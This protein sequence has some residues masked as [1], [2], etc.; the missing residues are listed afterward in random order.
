MLEDLK[1]HH[2]AVATKNITKSINVYQNLGYKLVSDVSSDP[3]QK[4]KVCFLE[5]ENHPCVELVEPLSEGSPVKEILKK[6][7]TTTY[8]F[9][10]E[11]ENIQ[12]IIDKLKK[13]RFVLLGNPVEAVAFDNR[14]ICFLYNTNYGL[15]EL[16]EK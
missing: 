9:C 6:S 4:V 8:H 15:I 2:I 13:L 1:F 3:I 7:G 10:Y 11:V 12:E 14:K 16:V 5:Q